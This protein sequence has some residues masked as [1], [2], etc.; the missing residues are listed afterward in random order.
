MLGRDSLVGM[1]TRYGLEGR[2]IEY[3]RGER[4]S[5][6]VQT[7]PGAHPQWVQSLF[8]GGKTA[9]GVAMTTHPI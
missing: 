5:A 7:G 8:P 1:A 3:Q 2:G 9:G 4:F 6:P